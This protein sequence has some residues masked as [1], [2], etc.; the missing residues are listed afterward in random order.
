MLLRVKL[1]SLPQFHIDCLIP[2]N[3]FKIVIQR[4]GITKKIDGAIACVL[5]GSS[6]L[7]TGTALYLADKGAKVDILDCD[8]KKANTVAQEIGG[9]AIQA[10]V[11]DAQVIV[12]AITAITKH[13]GIA[14]HIFINCAGVADAAH[15]VGRW[16]KFC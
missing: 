7:G 14:P 2:N 6:G 15:I 13:F 3:F 8:I 9:F 12:P 4:A 10:D 5:G 11:G 1:T 16:Q